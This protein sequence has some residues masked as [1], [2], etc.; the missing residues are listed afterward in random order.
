MDTR[1]VYMHLC[2]VQKTS[3]NQSL[4]LNWYSTLHIRW[5]IMRCFVFVNIK[6]KR[7][8]YSI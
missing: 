6:P 5:E 8:N 2:N 4:R 1:S 7:M 3:I